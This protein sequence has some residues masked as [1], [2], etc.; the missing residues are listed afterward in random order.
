[1][2]RVNGAQSG[3][4]ETFVLRRN[5][6]VLGTG[7]DGSMLDSAVF[8]EG[9]ITVGSPDDEPVNTPCR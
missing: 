9:I 7:G 3:D 4:T 8:F 6:S 1:M 2:V 5:R